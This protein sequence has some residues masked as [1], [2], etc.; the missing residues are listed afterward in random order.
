MLTLKQIE[1]FYWVAKLGTL[2]KAAAKIHITQSAATKRLQEVEAVSALPLFEAGN[3]KNVLTPKGRE[4]L[5]EC[6]K[7][8]AVMGELET[9]RDAK[10]QMAR[11]LHIGL[12]EVT[13]LTWFPRFLR[14]IKEI[15]PAI[16]V[17]PEIDL[18]SPLRRKVESGQLDL[19]VLPNP[20]P[21][22]SLARVAL[23][24]VQFGWLAMPG[25]FDAGRAY[26]LSEL[27]AYPVIEQK[28]DSIIT[29]LSAQL[30]EDAGVQPERI[31][32]GNNVHALAGLISAGVGIGC[33]PIRI[34]EKQIRQ[35]QL[36]QVKTTPA[37]PSVTYHCCFQKRLHPSLGYSIAE[38]AKASF[39]TP[40]R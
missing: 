15:Y 23:G 36:Q 12:T 7:L 13:A 40:G 26:A 10:Q 17:Q 14:K 38:I 5:A 30:W 9:L 34:F 1:A 32:G 3:R 21:S 16:T 19:A 20:A 8:F 35:K 4:L 22:D 2:N 37:A 18:S 6:E 24:P 25:T 28:A 29:D 11:V 33:L 27:A 39:S 31:Y